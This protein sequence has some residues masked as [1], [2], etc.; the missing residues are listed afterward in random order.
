MPRVLAA[1]TR[2]KASTPYWLQRST[3]N[4]WNKDAGPY[5]HGTLYLWHHIKKY[6]TS[7]NNET[8]SIFKLS[9]NVNILKK[10]QRDMHWKRLVNPPRHIRVKHLN[11][12]HMS[13]WRHRNNIWRTLNAERRGS[14]D[15]QRYK[16]DFI[17]KERIMNTYSNTLL[18]RLF[19][20]FFLNNSVVFSMYLQCNFV[21]FED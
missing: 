12:I 13:I 20:I 17:N 15:F 14:T 2:Y 11:A 5:I 6:S 19:N 8:I 18:F 3:V 4:A 10:W 1:V 16:L 21:F 9:K 7:C